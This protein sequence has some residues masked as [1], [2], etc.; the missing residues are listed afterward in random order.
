MNLTKTVFHNGV[1]TEN[2]FVLAEG[3][4]DDSVFHV[5]ALGLPPI[6]S[7]AK[8]RD[9]YGSI[10]FFGGPS[11]TCVAGSEKLKLIQQD[12]TNQDNMFVFVSDLWLDDP[13]VMAKFRTLLTGYSECPPYLFIICGNFL[14]KSLGV[15]QLSV[16]KK[17][18]TQLG[19]LIAQFPSLTETSRFLFVPGP[20]DPGPGNILPRPPL[21]ALL[22]QDLRDKVPFCEFVSNPCRVQYCSQEIVVYREDIINKMCRNALHLPQQLT[23]VAPHFVK[24]ILSQAHLCPLPLNVRP[25]YWGYDNAMHLYPLPDLVVCADKYDPYNVVNSECCVMNPG[26]FSKNKFRFNVYWPASR[27][28]EECKIED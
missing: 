24:T 20:Q 16:L 27:E 26:S 17:H 12:E 8:T 15:R 28:V 22:T 21:S 9:Y 23:D 5:T 14:S 11:K 18:F 3:S 10:N 13:K 25:V 1:F 7:S 19:N 6:E 2:C 4:Y